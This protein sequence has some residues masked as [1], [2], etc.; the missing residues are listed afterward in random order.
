[1]LFSELLEH[2]LNEKQIYELKHRTYL[3][4]CKLIQTQIRPNSET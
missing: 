3:H 2:W 1:M 4:Y